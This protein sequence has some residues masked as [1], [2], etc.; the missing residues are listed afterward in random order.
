MSLLCSVTATI[1][2]ALHNCDRQ[3]EWYGPNAWVTKGDAFSYEHQIKE[4]GILVS[5][6]IEVIKT[7]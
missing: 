6:V 7:V 4:M 2:S 3:Y 1:A 5:P